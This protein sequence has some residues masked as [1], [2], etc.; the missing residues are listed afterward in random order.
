MPTTENFELPYPNTSDEPNIPKD[1]QSLA[2]ATETALQELK[3]SVSHTE[4]AQVQFGWSDSK[5]TM[6]K[7]NGIV[8]TC[9]QMSMTGD[10]G[11]QTNYVM[12]Q[13]VP[14]GFRPE[15]FG[16]ILL[17]A[18]NGQTQEYLIDS[19]GKLSLS[20]LAANRGYYFTYSGTWIAA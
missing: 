15:H 4:A 18:N 9:G 6:V 2:T 10:L 5:F 1:F 8:T 17:I 19:N 16:A 13:T 20:T 7:R 14:E 12:S 11:P 3:D